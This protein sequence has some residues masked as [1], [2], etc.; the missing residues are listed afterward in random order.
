METTSKVTITLKKETI[1]RLNDF[2]KT[3]SIN[4]SGLIDRL[5]NEEINRKI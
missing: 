2:V 3:H 4:K 5:I 1:E